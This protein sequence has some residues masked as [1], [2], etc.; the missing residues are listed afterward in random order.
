MWGSNI[1][2]FGPLFSVLCIRVIIVRLHA[3]YYSFQAAKSS[4]MEAYAE[5][6]ILFATSHMDET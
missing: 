2:I 4:S 3:D 6:L 5:S 1:D